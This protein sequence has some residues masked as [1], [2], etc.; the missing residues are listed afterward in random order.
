MLTEKTTGKE[1]CFDGMLSAGDSY[2]TILDNI[3]VVYYGPGAVSVMHTNKECIN[4]DELKNAASIFALYAL[5]IL[6]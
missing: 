6:G 2:W 3:P 4:I 1:T 5:Q